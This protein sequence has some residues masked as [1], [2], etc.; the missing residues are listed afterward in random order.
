VEARSAPPTM[1]KAPTR[2]RQ[3]R[4]RRAGCAGAHEPARKCRHPMTA[5]AGRQGL[6]G[7]YL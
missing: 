2:A 4:G 1:V 5:L 7:G 6:A 3:Q